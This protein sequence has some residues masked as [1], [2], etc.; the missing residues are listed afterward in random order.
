M[1]DNN[2]TIGIIGDL[3][4]RERLGYAEYIKDG[5]VAERK[6]VLEAM[7][8]SLEHCDKIV[9]LGDSLNSRHNPSHVINEFVSLLKR[10]DGKQLYII[11]GNHE[12]TADG[13]TAIDFLESMKIP[14]WHVITN[15]VKEIDGMVF[16]PFYYRQQLGVTTNALATKHLMDL[17]AGHEAKKLFIH[18]AI[19][20]TK[21]TGSITTDQFDEI[22]L[23]ADELLKMYDV[24]YAGHIHHPSEDISEKVIIAGST[25]NN[26]VGESNKAIWTHSEKGTTKITL[27]GRGIYKI[28]NDIGALDNIPKKSIVKFVVTDRKL[29]TKEL[30]D[31]LAGFDAH[32]LLE[33]YDSKRQK[34]ELDEMMDF[35]IDKMLEVYAKERGVDIVKLKNAYTLIK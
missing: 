21:V 28:E 6:E 26:E 22:I 16:C 2:E 20:G 32:L 11:A 17:L 18:Q 29:R 25:F 4:L 1:K 9:F 33:R 3:H 10:F 5:R 7:V 24:V 31:K 12:K 8:K 23:P 27:P 19:S 13:R 14:S 15:S 34:K 30:D 35:D